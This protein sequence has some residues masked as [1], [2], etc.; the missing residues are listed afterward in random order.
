MTNLQ[1]T[2]IA[3]CGNSPKSE[4]I[5]QLTIAAFQQQY[6]QLEK[7]LAPDCKLEIAGAEAYIGSATIVPML[8]SLEGV[9]A[10]HIANAFTH[11]KQGAVNGFFKMDT[12]SYAFAV[13]F[14]FASAG[15]N[16][17]VQS[18]SCYVTKTRNQS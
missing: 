5:R 12:Q 16:A 10:V 14:T 15:K 2:G 3:S 8:S 18:I 1:V 11:G 17:K 9:T 4:L 13:I 6:Q 7:L